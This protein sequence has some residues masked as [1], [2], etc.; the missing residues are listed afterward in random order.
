MIMCQF[1]S[2][3]PERIAKLLREATGWD[4]GI[5][6]LVKI[7]RDIFDLKRA[8]NVKMGVKRQDDR[9]PSLLLRPLPNGGA[10][11]AVPDMEK[12]LADYYAVRDW[13]EEGTLKPERLRELGLA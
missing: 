6:E 7:G 9:L 10:Q 11:G 4:I 12:L 5:D 3:G 2:P 1:C 13:T 8:F